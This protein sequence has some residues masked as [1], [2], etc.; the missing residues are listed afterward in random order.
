MLVIFLVYTEDCN[1]PW[2]GGQSAG[3]QHVPGPGV[4]ST[5]PAECCRVEMGAYGSLI[6]SISKKEMKKPESWCE[7]TPFLNVKFKNNC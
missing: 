6:S 3:E 2:P 4:A 1:R 7:T 5:T